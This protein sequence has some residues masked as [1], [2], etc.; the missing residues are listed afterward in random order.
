MNLSLVKSLSALLPLA[1]SLAALALVV[2]HALMFGIVHEADE[3]TPAHIFQLLMAAQAPIIA[4]F[5]LKWL[6]RAPGQTL[7]VLALQTV[8]ALAAFAA[9]YFLT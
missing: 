8:A 6:P 1:M 4:F 2:G 5:A 7:R 9:V 3:G